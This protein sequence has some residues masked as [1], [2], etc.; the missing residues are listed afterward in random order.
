MG[1]TFLPRRAADSAQTNVDGEHVKRSNRC[2]GARRL[3]AT[4]AAQR[5]RHAD[6]SPSGRQEVEAILE[7]QRI[8]GNRAVQGVLREPSMTVQT[9]RRPRRAPTAG[10]TFAPARTAAGYIDLVREAERRLTAGGVGDIDQHIQ[11]LSGIYYG[12]DWSLDFETEHSAARNLAFQVYT[13]GLVRAPILGHFWVA[14]YSRR[15][16]AVRT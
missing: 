15:S 10:G 13:S 8:A 2:V 5:A 6:V 3:E 9:Q 16:S 14:R 4:P 11:V 7:L 12:T 1:R